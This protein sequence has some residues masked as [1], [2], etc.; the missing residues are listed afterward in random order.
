M[1]SGPIYVI[2]MGG[3][4]GADPGLLAANHV[5]HLLG[6]EDQAQIWRFLF[7][8]RWRIY[9]SS[10]WNRALRQQRVTIVPMPGMGHTGRGGYLDLKPAPGGGTPYMERTA[11]VISALI[12]R[13]S[14]PGDGPAPAL[15]GGDTSDSVVILPASPLRTVNGAT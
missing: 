15:H 8:G 10:E 12:R 4:F 2:S 13:H 14:A 5:Y 6:S 11:E 3:I 7:P 1:A 9:A